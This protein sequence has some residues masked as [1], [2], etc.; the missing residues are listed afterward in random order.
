VKSIDKT[1]ESPKAVN[2]LCTYI[3]REHKIVVF[4]II[5]DSC[6]RERKKKKENTFNLVANKIPEDKIKHITDFSKNRI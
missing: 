3:T 2:V 1:L 5:Y 6:I 4:T